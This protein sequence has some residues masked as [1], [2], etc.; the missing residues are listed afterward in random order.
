M[1]RRWGRRVLMVGLAVLA[2]LLVTV[3][4]V[5]LGPRLKGIAEREGTRY[6]ERPM[7]IGRIR[8]L[9]GRGEFEFTD[10]V[11]ESV[12]PEDVPVELSI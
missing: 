9:I 2:G 6:L 11:I 1:V 8:A 10:V 7:H 4:S 3:F 5:D 12:K